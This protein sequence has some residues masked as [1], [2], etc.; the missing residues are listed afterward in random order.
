MKIDIHVANHGSIFTLTPTTDGGRAWLE[1][2]T[3]PEA[4]WWCGGVVVEP[5]Y[6]G[7]VCAG[8]IADGLVVR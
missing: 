8:A 3:D 1:E 4:T 7:D 6:V 5:R 2:H